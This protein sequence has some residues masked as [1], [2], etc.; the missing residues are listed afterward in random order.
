MAQQTQVYVYNQRA[1]VVAL[2][3][4]G[5]YSTRRFSIVYAKDLMIQRGVNNVLQF[6]FINQD[7]K[8]VSVLGSNI[9][10]RIISNDGGTLLFQK[11]VTQILPLT[12]ITQIQMTSDECEAIPPQQCW[13]S[14]EITDTNGTELLN[15]GVYTDANG[16]CRGTVKI[17]DSIFPTVLNSPPITIPSHPQPSTANTVTYYTSTYFTNGQ[18]VNTFQC[19][20]C[21][22]IGNISFETSNVQDFVNNQTIENVQSCQDGFNISGNTFTYGNA[23]ANVPYS[24]TEGYTITGYYPYI[25]IQINNTGSNT[26]PN[27]G[28]NQNTLANNQNYLWGDMTEAY[29]R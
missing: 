17:V 18:M 11:T 5:A 28:S 1:Y 21:N 10:F 6:A 22:F 16:K 24:G 20:Y 8:P 25:R 12:G 4:T 7:Q 13:Y 14:L 9:L 19:S 27:L 26:I 29:V 2:D 15:Q 23:P 3:T